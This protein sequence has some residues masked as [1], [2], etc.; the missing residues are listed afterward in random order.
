MTRIVCSGLLVVVTS[1]SAAAQADTT[2]ANPSWF[3]TIHSGA[4]FGKKDYP[5]STIT[6]FFDI[7]RTASVMQGIHYKRFGLGVGIGYDVY[8][9]WRTMPIFAGALYDFS[10][11]ANHSFY[12]Q[13]NS[14]YSKAWT[15]VPDETQLNNRGA[16][17][18]FHYCFLG[19]RVQHGEMTFHFAAGYKFQRLT[20]IHSPPSWISLYPS[21]RT[22]VQHDVRRLSIELGIG[23]R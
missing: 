7:G 10:K 23:L 19:Y 3:L 22:T 20:Y 21:Y 5:T 1:L 15:T 13:V 6:S 17:G 11:R 14:G 16:G 9:E 4:L 8:S 2:F 12:V 18:S